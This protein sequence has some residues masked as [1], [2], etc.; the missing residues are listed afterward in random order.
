MDAIEMF[1]LRHE[2][3]HGHVARALDDLT[4]DQAR[5]SLLPRTNPIAWLLWHIAR[6]EDAAVSRYVCDAPQLLDDDWLAR[7]NV[8]RRDV[9]TGMTPDEVAD[10]STRVELGTLMEYWD[11]LATR[12]PH[13]VAP[14][15]PSDLDQVVEPAWL[16]EVVN[17]TVSIS[18]ASRFEQFCRGTTRGQFL[19]W[20]PLTHNAEHVGQVDF[21]RGA[22]GQPGRF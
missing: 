4:D 5:G 1:L 12:T 3:I 16:H 11:A 18:A 14:L 10:I 2:R 19:V 8:E 21:I 15:R 22:L 20:L 13:L 17:E 6:T 7:L 9:G